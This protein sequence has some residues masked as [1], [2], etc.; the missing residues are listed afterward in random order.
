MRILS[1]DSKPIDAYQWFH[2]V[3]MKPWLSGKLEAIAR[4]KS[5]FEDT[6]DLYFNMAI[7]FSK[8]KANLIIL[9][10]STKQARV[11]TPN[12][13]SDSLDYICDMLLVSF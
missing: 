3:F 2:H 6:F 4:R 10:K 13:H 5:S 9:L 8:V 12:F 1:L 11:V 7:F